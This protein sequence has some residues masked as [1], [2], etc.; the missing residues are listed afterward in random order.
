MVVLENCYSVKLTESHGKTY[1]YLSLYLGLNER[2][3]PL[4]MKLKEKTY[5]GSPLLWTLVCLPELCASVSIWTNRCMT[6]HSMMTAD[7]ATDFTQFTAL[8]NSADIYHFI[9]MYLMEK[10]NKDMWPACQRGEPKLKWS[11]CFVYHRGKKCSILIK[12]IHVF[13]W[14][15][16]G[17]GVPSQFTPRICTFYRKLT[18]L[19]GTL[20]TLFVSMCKCNIQNYYFYSQKNK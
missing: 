3:I 2:S 9:W 16:M 12:L 13:N 8:W 10:L 11:V 1:R 19:N 7:P 4:K 20:Q 18:G 14:G 15:Y 6:E 5:T 17:L